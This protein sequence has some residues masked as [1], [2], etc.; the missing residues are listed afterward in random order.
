MTFS[1]SLI[2][3]FLCNEYRIMGVFED[4]NAFELILDVL[5]KFI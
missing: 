3:L 2:I 4:F 1:Q 5:N